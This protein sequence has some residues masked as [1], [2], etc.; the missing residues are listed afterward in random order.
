M[1]KKLTVLLLMLLLLPPAG[2][3]AQR[4]RWLL[5]ADSLHAA[6]GKAEAADTLVSAVSV[7]LDSTAVAQVLKRLPVIDSLPQEAPA[8]PPQTG[9]GAGA[10]RDGKG[11]G[12]DTLDIQAG[13]LLLVLALN[14]LS[15]HRLLLH[16]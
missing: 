13:R 1:M 10:F 4:A 15:P 3:Y 14:R 16:L 7:T 9:V 5:K 12:V 11:V 2:L 8:V 6:R